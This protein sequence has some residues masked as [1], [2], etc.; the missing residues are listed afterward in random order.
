MILALVGIGVMV[1]LGFYMFTAKR[2]QLDTPAALDAVAGIL[3][4]VTREHG[5]VRGKLDGRPAVYVNYISRQTTYSDI[6]ITV[7]GGRKFDKVE[8]LSLDDGLRKRVAAL[9]AFRISS[10]GTELRVQARR[11]LQ[12]GEEARELVGVARDLA[13]AV[14]R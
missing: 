9:D 13:T 6:R 2:Q 3:T 12:T 5:T 11:I 8:E 10:D 4:E 7:A 14:T 1:A